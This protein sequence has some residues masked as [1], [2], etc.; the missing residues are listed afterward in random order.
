[1]YCSFLLAQKRTKKGS[2]SLG[3]PT[4]DYPALVAKKGRFGKSLR[5]AKTLFLSLLCCSAA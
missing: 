1:M 4:A 2:R 5:S 3:Q